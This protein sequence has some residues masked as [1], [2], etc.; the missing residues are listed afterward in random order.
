MLKINFLTR[1][2]LITSL[3]CLLFCGCEK[4]AMDIVTETIDIDNTY[5]ELQVSDAISAVISNTVEQVSVN[6]R[7]NMINDVIIEE[8]DGILKVR[9]KEKFNIFSSKVKV[10]LPPNPNL[11][12][13]TLSEASDL[14]G[15]IDAEEF[16]FNLADASHAKVQGNIERLTMNLE[17]ASHAKVQGH[18]EK[19]TINLE[20]AS[21]IDR[22]IIDNRY[23]L[24]CDEC[25][26]SLEDASSVYLHCD[27]NINVIK[28]KGASNF[29]Y[30]GNASIKYAEGT[31]SGGSSVIQHD[32]L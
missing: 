31:S 24:S 20:D 21:H 4:F 23:A 30:T 5:T 22:Q 2:T 25:N 28:L 9:M 19:L 26:V 18:I 32:V 12:K 7:E 6:A 10:Q 14:E 27:G 1:P 8:S 15:E 16:L 11:V 29:H 3:L 13:V 17:D